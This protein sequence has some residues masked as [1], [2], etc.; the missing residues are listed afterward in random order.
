MAFGFVFIS[1]WIQW[2]SSILTSS[3]FFISAFSH[4]KVVPGVGEDCHF[5]S[6]GSPERSGGFNWRS[7]TSCWADLIGLAE[8]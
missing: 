4:W 6:A 1:S 8:G 2:V 5:L 3:T 7:T